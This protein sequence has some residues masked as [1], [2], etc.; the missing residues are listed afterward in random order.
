M[1]TKNF[2]KIVFVLTIGM[3]VSSCV[4][5]NSAGYINKG[6]LSGIRPSLMKNQSEQYQV[7]EDPTGTA[8]SHLVEKFTVRDGD[9]SRNANWSDCKNDRQRSE[10]TSHNITRSTEGS[11]NWYRWWIYYPEDYPMDI[12]M[13]G[14][15]ICNVQF[16]EYQILDPAW[17]FKQTP[18]GYGLAG[19]AADYDV[20][21]NYWNL[22]HVDDLKGKWHEITLHV[23]WS[24]TNGFFRVWVNGKQKV[25]YYG[26]TMRTGSVYFKYGIYQTSV[27][28][29]KDYYGKM[30]TQVVYYSRM[31]KSKNRETLQ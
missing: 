18:G 16:K 24:K 20:L 1:T 4:S 29:Y 19:H 22:I 17:M 13:S 5:S 14:V 12:S 26:R 11:S 6:G 21:G 23:K 8:P 25:D 27:S 2:I 3:M 15:K 31:S 10:L 7:I 30:P 9:C 28:R